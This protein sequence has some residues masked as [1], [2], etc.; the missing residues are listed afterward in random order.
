MQCCLCKKETDKIVSETQLC[1]NG[2]SWCYVVYQVFAA[3]DPF[4]TVFETESVISIDEMF[5]LDRIK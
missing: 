1:V 3:D 5:D 2:W 4:T